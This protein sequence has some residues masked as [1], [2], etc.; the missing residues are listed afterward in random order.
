FTL[1][2]SEAIATL[3]S[4]RIVHRDIHP[5]NVFLFMDD[6]KGYWV[7]LGD[8]GQSVDFTDP[9]QVEAA[10]KASEDYDEDED[11]Q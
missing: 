10:V 1:L 11:S 6:K 4:Q 5:N 2:L 9:E 3:H 8:L 7:V